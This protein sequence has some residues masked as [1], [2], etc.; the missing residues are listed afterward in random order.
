MAP[1]ILRLDDIRLTFGGAPLLDD[2][3]LSVSAGDRIALVGRN[4]SGKSTLL[5][6][7][8]GQ[9]E[10]QDGDHLPAAFDHG[11]LSSARAGY[12][13]FC[14]CRRLC[15]SRAR[16]GAMTPT[17]SPICSIISASAADEIPAELSGGE[18]R[19]AALARVLAPQPD[20]L[21]LDE[22]TNH[23]DLVDHRMAGRGAGALRRRPWSSSR[24]TGG[25]S[26]GSRAPPSGSIVAAPAASNAALLRSRH[27][28]TPCWRRK[29]ATSTSSA[30]RS[31][32]RST[33]C[34]TASRPGAT[35]TCAGWASCRPCASGSAT[36]AAP[37]APPGLP[38]PRRRI[39]ASW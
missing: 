1:P 32:A 2:A 6:I 17:A 12:R 23:L 10:P 13:R 30:A 21:L 38:L 5:K 18:A 4:G 9:V 28:A 19:R 11:A 35:A 34:A 31:C 22:P 24:T 39:P 37:R 36:T 16:P 26:S 33:G 3:S 15:R 20:I 8:A 29:S 25:S 27:G 14:R 7:A